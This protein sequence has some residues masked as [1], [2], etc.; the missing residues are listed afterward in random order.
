MANS[1]ANVLLDRLNSLFPDAHKEKLIAQAYDGASAMRGE[2]ARVQQKVRKHF[3]NAHYVH[4]YAHQLNLIMQQATSTIPAMNLFFFSGLSGIASFFVRSPKRTSILDEVV[5]RRLP[6]ASTTRWNFNSRT[7]NTVHEHLEDL[8]QCF[9]TINSSGSFDGNTMREACGF[10][11]TLQDEDFQLFLQ[12]FSQIMPH[13]D[14]LY[15]KLQK[16]D[17]DAVF[18]KRALQI[19]MSSVEAIRQSP[20]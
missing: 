18:I 5:A 4:C 16:K 19:F 13:V 20:R 11:R 1:I 2:P 10:L 17:I 12:L 15:K 8:V 7:V 9:E 14:I 6:R 3:Q